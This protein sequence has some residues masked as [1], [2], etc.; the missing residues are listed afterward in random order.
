MTEK[1]GFPS[2]LRT[3]FLAILPII[4]RHG[5]VCFRH[6]KCHSK[7]EEAIAEMVALSFKWFRR[8]IEKGKDPNKFPTT[9]A[10]Y[11]ARAVKCGRR[12]CGQ[13][14]PKDV[15][16]ERAQQRHGF[17]VESLPI[18]TR[19]CH[20]E[21]NGIS[22]QRHLDAYEERLQDNTRTP[23]D[24]QA[25]FRIDFPSWLSTRTERDR[26]II[27]DMAIGERTLALA[28]KH[29]ISPSRVSQLRRDFH[30]DWQIFTGEAGSTNDHPASN[31]FH[32]AAASR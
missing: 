23:P 1:N 16:S 30:D 18:S 26:R 19:T 24:E 2:D 20:E 17:H 32:P 6:I 7:K 28:N 29:G 25:A 11:A 21:L 9:L 10:T 14:K 27:G 15:L 12:L 5:R 3:R 8:L 4:E 13:L 22:G 31:G